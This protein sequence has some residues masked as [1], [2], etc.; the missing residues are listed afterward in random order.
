MSE[1]DIVPGP[2]PGR[3]AKVNEFRENGTSDFIRYFSSEKIHGRL[4]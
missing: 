4:H 2:Q 3:A 1:P